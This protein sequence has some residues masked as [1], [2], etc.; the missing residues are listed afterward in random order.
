[1]MSSKDPT[2]DLTAVEMLRLV[3]A[4]VRDMKAR[5]SSLESETR[6]VAS[7]LTTLETEVVAQRSRSFC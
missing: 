3:L 1:M 5:L 6:G 4:D 2:Q 7:R